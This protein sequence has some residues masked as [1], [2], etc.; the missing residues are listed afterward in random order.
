MNELSKMI[1]E[2]MNDI[3]EELKVQLPQIDL[4]PDIDDQRVKQA[5]LDMS[6]TGWQKLFARF[7]QAE[8]IKYVNEFSQRRKF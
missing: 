2:S 4:S 8:V 1:A 7:G 5:I 6:S 3:K